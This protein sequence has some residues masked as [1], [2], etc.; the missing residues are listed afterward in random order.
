MALGDAEHANR[1]RPRGVAVDAGQVTGDKAPQMRKL[2]GE[3]QRLI[4]GQRIH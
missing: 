2:A 3:Q 4:G 1:Q